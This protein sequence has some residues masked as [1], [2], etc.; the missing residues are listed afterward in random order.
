MKPNLKPLLSLKGIQRH[1]QSGESVVK[2]LDGVDIEIFAGEFVAIMGQS[3][4]GKSTLMNI[5]GCLDKP[6]GGTYLI[7][8]KDVSGFEGD[9]LA[10]LRRETFGFVFQRY[11]LL[12]TASA[13]ENVEIP[14]IY[15]GMDKGARSE[16]AKSLLT[17]L[18]LGGR[19][20]HR[21]NQLSGGQ[22]QRVAIARALMNNAPVI[23]ADEPTGAL[24]SASGKD[25]MQ[26]LKDLHA[27]G[28]TVILITH[29][30]NVA[31]HAERQITIQDGRILR[32]SGI[33]KVGLAD[34]RLAGLAEKHAVENPTLPEVGE[35]VQTALRSLRVNMFRTALTLLGIV[36][37][38]ASVVTMLAVG[39][40]SSE[41]VVSQISAMG[42]NMLS[43]RP[44]AA[45]VRSSG[46]NAS[47][48]VSDGEALA[49]VENVRVVVPERSGRYTLRYGSND[50]SSSV[51]GVNEGLPLTRDWALAKG[52]FF[53]SRDVSSYAPVI[54][55]GQTVA[56][57]LFGPLTDPIGEKVLV[58]NVP[59]EVIGVLATKGAN[60]M[61]SDQD[62]VAYIPITTGLVRLFGGNYV[63]GLNVMVDDVA[64]ID[65]TQETINS[66]LKVRHRGVEN[67]SIRNTASLLDMVNETQGTLTILLGTVAAI[68]LLV[69]GIGV[70]NIMLVSVTERTREIGVRMAVGARR[71]DIMVQFITEAAVV[72]ILG[73]VIGVTLGIV[74]GLGLEAFGVNVAFTLGPPMMAFGCA[75]ATGLVFG[76]VPARKAAGLDP[77]V[78]LSSE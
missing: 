20:G 43:V 46:D 73:G 41:K 49:A 19:D 54:V 33:G 78:A 35:A 38:V 13:A 1:Y 74:L 16:R 27:E 12:G 58:K 30:A 59:F 31:A 9:R 42:T 21:P 18:G 10:G 55:L 64:R 25:V 67:F 26:L 76:F 72:G 47:L 8:G 24:D 17:K 56:T 29:D 77:V 2:A 3:G 51:S 75:F 71:G 45:G 36:I 11:N 40:G 50:Y 32:D 48:L 65:A 4:S 68:S 44:G 53:T 14:A 7:D 22:Q 34:S 6:S 60:I 62:D 61:G 23:L 52:S 37:G 28:R 63:S 39:N 15:A 66:L 5:L 69:G 70:M 57:S